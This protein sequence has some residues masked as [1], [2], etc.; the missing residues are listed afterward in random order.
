MKIVLVG[1]GIMPIPPTGWGAVE[2]LIWD[3]FNQLTK[4]GHDVRIVNTANKSEII[5]LVNEIKYDV[6]H[7]HY[8][9]HWD[10]IPHLTTP[11]KIITSHYPY[12]TDK[13]KWGG[14][15]YDKIM[16]GF[17]Q[18]S[19]DPTTYIYCL[20]KSC[21]NMFETFGISCDK[22]R[23]IPNGI[24][25]ENVRFDSDVKYNGKVLCV[26]K[27]E[28]RKRQYLT[29]D[30]DNIYYVGKGDLNH[31]NFL[32]EWS[33][34]KILNELTNYDGFILLSQEENDSLALKE[35]LVAGL[36]C[37]VS[38]GTVKN[39]VLEPNLMKYVLVIPENQLNTKEEIRE[40]INNHIE[41]CRP[42]REEIRNLSIKYFSFEGVV[43]T[44]INLLIDN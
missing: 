37:I 39:I 28:P 31:E 16:N 34:E 6:V 44:Y 24:C 43:K 11:L 23:V 15:G 5:K 41:V 32:G 3:Y 40:L 2:L 38:E 20:N 9:E 26:A 35:A 7:L 19:L 22:L 36:P 17:K 10:V 21:V 14:D 1:P 27:I 18:I 33:R 4:M 42:F 30:L 8:D 13:S 29:Y 12:I 25:S